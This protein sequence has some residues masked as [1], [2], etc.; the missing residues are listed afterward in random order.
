MAQRIAPS[1]KIVYVD[2]DPSVIAHSRVLLEENQQTLIVPADIFTPREVLEDPSI[3]AFLEFDTPIALFLL[4]SC[5][6]T[7]APRPPPRPSPSTSTP[8][9][10]APTSR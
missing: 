9:P 8:S 4:A 2:N 10:R 6:T 1:S 5:T 3:R 7:T